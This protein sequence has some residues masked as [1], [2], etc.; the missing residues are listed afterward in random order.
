MDRA[1]DPGGLTLLTIAMVHCDNRLANR[2]VLESSRLGVGVAVWLIA[3]NTRPFAGQI[4]VRPTLLL[5]GDAEA[6]PTEQVPEP[7]VRRGW[8][9]GLLQREG[10]CAARIS[11]RSLRSRVSV[12]RAG[13]SL[14]LPHP[15]L[16]LHL[17]LSTG[18]YGEI[19]LLGFLAGL[20]LLGLGMLAVQIIRYQVTD[21]YQTTLAVRVV[22]LPPG[23]SYSTCGVGIPVS[24]LARGRW[25]WGAL[26]TSICYLLDRR[27]ASS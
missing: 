14:P 21:L 5:P 11:A 24:R 12:G 20:L 15:V 17:L 2:I 26:A 10:T 27:E 3:A 4:S 16:R 6:G 22:F 7:S 19:L 25:R 1:A 18:D 13:I 23:S 9:L 8:C